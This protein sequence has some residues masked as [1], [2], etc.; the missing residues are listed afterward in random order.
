MREWLKH[1]WLGVVVSVLL[2]YGVFLTS[3]EIGSVNTIRKENLA[4]QIESNAAQCKRGNLVRAYLVVDA[5]R[6]AKNPEGRQ[7]AARAAFPILNCE[8]GKPGPPPNLPQ[9]EQR[10]YIEDFEAKYPADN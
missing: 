3:Q 1:N 9:D 10:K 5:S 6:N 2:A 4:A 7:A 8:T